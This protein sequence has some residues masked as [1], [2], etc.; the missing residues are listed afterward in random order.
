M[1]DAAGVVVWQWRGGKVGKEREYLLLHHK[2][3]NEWGPPKGSDSLDDR[4]LLGTALHSLQHEVPTIPMSFY[5]I[6]VWEFVEETREILDLSQ[7]LSSSVNKRQAT[8]IKILI[9]C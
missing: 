5:M 1:E 6:C 3:H 7:F 4:G 9:F 8:W 2:P